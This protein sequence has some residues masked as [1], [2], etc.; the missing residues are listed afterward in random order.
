MHLC[1]IPVLSILQRRHPLP[2][3]AR[4][5]ALNRLGESQVQATYQYN[6]QGTCVFPHGLL[7]LSSS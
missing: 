6:G 5:F 2:L 4:N 7:L 1:R 3:E